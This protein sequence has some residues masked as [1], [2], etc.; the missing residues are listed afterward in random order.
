MCLTQCNFQ[1]LVYLIWRRPHGRSVK[2]TC[3]L[4]LRSITFTHI[5]IIHT[6]LH[7]VINTLHIQVVF[8][9]PV[10][11]TDRVVL[12]SAVLFWAAFQLVLNQGTL[13]VCLKKKATTA[14]VG[15]LKNQ[16]DSQEFAKLNLLPSTS[17]NFI[18]FSVVRPEVTKVD[19]FSLKWFSL[20]ALEI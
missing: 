4:L 11:W 14:A 1:F 7:T 9:T 2:F 8:I 16:S 13:T 6:W 12:S 10:Q 19:C 18:S 3:W 15:I 17:T 20:Q 5:P